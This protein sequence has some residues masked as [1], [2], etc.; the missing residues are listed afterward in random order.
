M[1][2]KGRVLI[3]ED[4]ARWQAVV[5]DTLKRGGFH[6][7]T[8][9][10]ITTA[11][12]CLEESFFHLAVLDLHMDQ[13]NGAE[14]LTLLREI[15]ERG[16]NESMSVIM[17]TGMGTKEQ[18]REAFAQYKVMDFLAKK[19]FDNLE[20]L[21][22]VRRIFDH[23]LKINLDLKVHWQQMSG[24][25]D[26]VT[27]LLLDGKRLKPEDPMHQTITAEFDDL[28]CRLYHNAESVI[29]KRLATGHSGAGLLW[30]QPFYK[31]TGGAHPSVLKFGDFREI[32]IEFRNWNN[33]VKSFVS[34]GRN[35]AIQDPLG[36]TPRLGG[37][38]YSLLEAPGE[39]LASFGD[40]YKQATQPDINNVLTR[41]FT[42][43]C[44]SWY[45]NAGRLQPYDLTQDYVELMGLSR[46]KIERA[47]EEKLKS[48]QGKLQL[49]FNSLPSDRRFTNPVYALDQR[50]VRPTYVCTTHGDF[51]ESNILVDNTGHSWLIDFRRTGPGH[52][53]RDI[54]ELD[55]TVRFRLLGRDDATLEERLE[56]EERLCSIQHFNQID[57][58][59]S[60]TPQNEA[61]AK[62]YATSVHLRSIARKLVSQNP[63]DDISEYYIA[64]FYFSINM[65]RFYYLPTIQ[66]E[67][68]LLSASLLAEKLTR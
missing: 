16:L 30:V 27:N 39:Q 63:N 9:G 58:L 56:M 10:T 24:P 47:F 32:A 5:G 66:R 14:G 25:E 12:K 61:V 65:L 19:D 2:R 50:F 26:A 41:L 37:I 42:E 33:Y 11:Q 59:S 54:A 18:M 68:A 55:A 29:V 46:E 44:S 36:R 45:G 13:A 3:V 4:D 15:R 20:F 8:A 6:V 21:N 60:F 7:D 67:H 31:E 38:T 40:F 43:T 62:A 53:L 22:Q 57:S 28:L 23:L 48:V 51:N 34:G 1:I 52:I 17:L 49:H 35:T 64:L